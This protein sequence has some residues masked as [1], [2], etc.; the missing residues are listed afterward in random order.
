MPIS[1]SAKACAARIL[2][3]LAIME[4]G[5]INGGLTIT[6]EL[7]GTWSHSDIGDGTYHPS[8]TWKAATLPELLAVMETFPEGN[9]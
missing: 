5:A 4:D 1:E 7:D 6:R 3:V 2:T 9:V 8:A